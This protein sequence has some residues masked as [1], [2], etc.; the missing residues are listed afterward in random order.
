MLVTLQRR[1]ASAGR[2]G[3]DAVPAVADLRRMV[4]LPVTALLALLVAGVAAAP[5]PGAYALLLASE[6]GIV[7]NATA[8]LALAGIVPALD[9]VRRRRALRSPWIAAWAGCFVVGLVFLAGEETSWGQ[10]WFRWDTPAWIGQANTQNETNLHNYAKW[11]EDLPKSVLSAAVLLTGIVWPIWAAW[12]GP[13]GWLRR[14]L[15]GAI[16]PSAALWPSA[17]IAF[18]LRL[19]ER[20]VANLPGADSGAPLFRSLREGLE[21]F[22]VLFV[23]LY[24]LELRQRHL[25]GAP[26]AANP[27]A[28]AATVR[29]GGGSS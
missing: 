6:Q 8:C 2:S 16:W 24:L 5:F 10:Q 4:L 23:V 18:A 19:A 20:G 12:G 26:A 28:G 21:L 29:A 14:S 17:A 11:S 1:L 15:L 25:R 9:L 27:A 13:D 22:L 7:E 3:G